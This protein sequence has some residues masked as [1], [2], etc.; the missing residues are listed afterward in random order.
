MTSCPALRDTL[1]ELGL[2]Y[3]DL[4]LIHWPY[5]FQAGSD[6]F[7]KDK[8]GKLI[9][10]TETHFTETWAAI[11]QC[12][13]TGLTRSVGLSNFNSKQIDEVFAMAKIKPAVLQVECHPYLQQNKLIAHA[14]ARGM[15]V[16]AYSPLG[17]PDRPAAR[18]GD[19]TILS[20][21]VLTAIGAKYGKSVAQVCIRFQV[22]RGVVCIPKSVTASRIQANFE[23]FDFVLSAGDMETIAKLDRSWRAC[24]PS[25]FV[26]GKAVWRDVAHP[27]FP[28]HIEF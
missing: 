16:T 11:E 28:Y 4:W 23:V 3:L 17:S 1:R 7:P 15:V 9:F 25:V 20:D 22:Q 21:P 18:P 19:P 14:T 10:D 27:L 26:D 24:V 8:D 12:V 6:M 5:A 13:S 2:D